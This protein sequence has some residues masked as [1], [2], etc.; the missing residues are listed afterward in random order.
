MY[1]INDDT[2]VEISDV[3][4]PDPGA[5]LPIVHASENGLQI[6]FYVAE[7]DSH[8]KSSHAKLWSDSDELVVEDCV[9]IVTCHGNYAHAFGPP[10]DEAF[11]GHP[12]SERGLHPYGVFEVKD[13]SWIRAFEQMN[14]VHEAHSPEAF[15][16]YRHFVISFHDSTFEC[17][18]H[19]LTFEVYNG[20]VS[21]IFLE[22]LKRASDLRST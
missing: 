5:P 21:E 22:K 19:S 6:A 12:L 4:S 14:S 11:S 16:Q 17:V 2:V 3:P 10:N 9:A 20:D 13:S 8:W 15:S 18:G 1:S 7:G